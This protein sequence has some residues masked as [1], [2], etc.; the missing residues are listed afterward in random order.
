MKNRNLIS[1]AVAFGFLSIGITGIL[2]YFGLEGGVTTVHVIFGLLFVALSLFHVINNWNSIKLYTL[3]KQKGGIRKEFLLVNAILLAVLIGAAV[4]LQ[5]F[6][7]IA[8]AGEEGGRGEEGEEGRRER[9]FFRNAS[10]EEVTTNEDVQGTSLSF[11]IQKSNNVLAPSMAIWVV[12]SAGRFAGNLFVPSKV[13][14]FKTENGEERRERFEGR[15]ETEDL[16]PELLTEWYAASGGSGFNY[17]GITPVE[18]F[19]LNTKTAVTGKFSVLVEITYDNKKE[20]YRADVDMTEGK[21]FRLESQDN[22]LLTRAIL[23]VVNI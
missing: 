2:M 19:F 8:H 20:V 5:P 11:I 15:L 9:G 18:N 6:T 7:A 14:K 4:N 23:E 12:D 13:A 1:L 17:E 16:K 10:F 22:K 21:L 3:D